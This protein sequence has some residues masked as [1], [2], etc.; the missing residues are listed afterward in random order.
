MKQFIIAVYYIYLNI[1]NNG[2]FCI[3]VGDF[4]LSQTPV[5]CKYLGEKYGLVPEK[6]EDKWHAEMINTQLHD[7]LAEGKCTHTLYITGVKRMIIS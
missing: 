6:E 5:I 2:P 3:F 1:S 4:Q 7:Y